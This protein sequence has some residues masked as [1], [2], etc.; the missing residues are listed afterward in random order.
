V[1]E[2]DDVTGARKPS[3][4]GVERAWRKV[5]DVVSL[6]PLKPLRFGESLLFCKCESEQPMRAFKL[7]GAWHRLTDMSEDE[8]KGGVVAFSSGNHAQGVAWSAKRL[9]MPAL[10][11]MP[12]DTPRVKLEGTHALGA[13]IVLYDRMTEKREVIAAR[14]AEERGATLVPSFD[15]PWVVEGQGSAGLEAVAQMAELGEGPPDMVIMPCGGGGLAAGLALALPE[16]RVVVVEPE[17]WDDMGNS[18]RGGHIVP[19][20]PNPP[21]TSCDA[22]QTLQ[23][24][25]ITFDVLKARGAIGVAVSEEETFAAMRHAKRALDLTIEPGGAVAL[26]AIL[27]G[28]VTPGERTLILLSGGNV[29]PALFDRVMAG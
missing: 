18:L 27:S 1:T 24:A 8:R 15:D 16:A 20:G 7:R 29:D 11:V 22:I 19:V 6:T 23:V 12:R 5:A 21:P 25:P 3:F 26:A 28:K 4:S 2:R 17:G 10:I 13:E 9:G 14:I